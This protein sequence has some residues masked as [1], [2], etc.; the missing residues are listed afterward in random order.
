MP[1]FS[2]TD[3]SLSFDVTDAIIGPEP[4]AVPR[5]ETW[6]IKNNTDPKAKGACIRECVRDFGHPGE[7]ELGPWKVI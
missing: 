7:C 6:S 5:C 1:D 4:V 2:L 3:Y